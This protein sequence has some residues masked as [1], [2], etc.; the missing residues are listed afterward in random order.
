MCKTEYYITV[1]IGMGNC[2]FTLYFQC[3]KMAFRLFLA[4]NICMEP[5]RNVIPLGKGCTSF[6][7]VDS[8]L[9]TLI[10]LHLQLLIVAF[11]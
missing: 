4:T 6:A 2:A 5:C 1:Y 11:T 10:N 7:V 8:L 9:F 3:F